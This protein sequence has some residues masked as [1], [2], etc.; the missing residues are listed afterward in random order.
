MANILFHL[1]R[2]PLINVFGT[3]PDEATFKTYWLNRACPE[4]VLRMCRPELWRFEAVAP[5]QSPHGVQMPLESA[6]LAGD[7]FFVLD[8]FFATAMVR[9]ANV[10]YWVQQGFHNNPQFPD[11]AASKTYAEMRLSYSFYRGSLAPLYIDTHEGGSQFRFVTCV[12]DPSFNHC[13]RESSEFNATVVLSEEKKYSEF[14]VKLM[15]YAVG[16]S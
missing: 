10:H 3:S 7:A 5:G 2:S 11:F 1:K 12:V 15:A 14:A 8:S 9:T 6:S 4:D 13:G 16:C